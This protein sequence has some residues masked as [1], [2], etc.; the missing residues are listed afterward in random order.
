MC[1]IVS[2]CALLG[3]SLEHGAKLEGQLHAAL[4]RIQHRGPDGRGIWVEPEGGCG[5]YLFQLSWRH[6]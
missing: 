2:V 1:G 5:P 3:H 4:D 6:C